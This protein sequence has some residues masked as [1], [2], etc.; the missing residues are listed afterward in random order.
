MFHS[1]TQRVPELVAGSP[2]SAG[3]TT[4]CK[5]LHLLVELAGSFFLPRILFVACIVSV[6]SHV[7]L[8]QHS[9][10]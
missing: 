9:S 10:Q 7:F 4:L 8:H 2:Q 5:A 3:C 6:L 1:W